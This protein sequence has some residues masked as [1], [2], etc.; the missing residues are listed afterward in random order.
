MKTRSIL[1][2]AADW[3]TGFVASTWGA[4]FAV[5][6]LAIWLIAARFYGWERTYN[7]VDEFVTATTFLLLF[8][9][10]RSQAK[11]SLAAQ[12]KLNE[13]LA[14]VQKASPRLINVEDRTES[15][16]RELHALYEK[17]QN[18]DENSH[19]IREISPGH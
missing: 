17:L 4:R 10:Q 12:T 6:L 18:L 19:S 13:L 9:L 11:D 8:L 7:V 15:E 16:L 5:I 14:A 3:T 2:S 1:E